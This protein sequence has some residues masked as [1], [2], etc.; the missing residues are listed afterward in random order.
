MSNR[1][2]RGYRDGRIEE[3][4]TK[5][6]PRFRIVWREPK[7]F[8][9]PDLGK[10]RM[11]KGGF[12]TRRDAQSQLRK[13]LSRVEDGQP[14]PGGGAITVRTFLTEF[15]AAHRVYSSTAET[16]AKIARL[17][18]YPH[19]G[20]RKLTTI[21]PE[22]LAGLYRLLEER[23]GQKGQPLSPS[24]VA[25][26]H[27]VLSV[28]FGSPTAMRLVGHNPALARLSQPPRAT[29]V[30]AARTPV[31]VW[32]IPQLHD[33]LSWNETSGDPNWA[34]WQLVAE[35]G[36]RR[37]EVAALTWGDLDMRGSVLRVQRTVALV[38]GPDGRLLTKEKPTKGYKSRVVA[39]Y[40][41]TVDALKRH[42]EAV[43]KTY[44]FA[45]IKADK[46]MPVDVADYAAI[47]QRVGSMW[48]AHCKRFLTT[49]GQEST[50]AVTL[51]GLRHT[52]ATHLFLAGVH[53]K[54]VQERLGH[55]NAS[56][57]Q[58]I[59]THMLPTTQADAITKLTALRKDV[60]ASDDSG[61]GDPDPVAAVDK[62]RKLLAAAD[63]GEGDALAQLTALRQILLTDAPSAA[64]SE[65]VD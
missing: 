50:P 28:A 15:L 36:I 8:E 55:A 19:I 46:P 35:T 47:P 45:A 31:I 12:R 54:I 38:H 23:G 56:I 53:P 13:E 2:R 26:V 62:L 16:Y 27:E 21:R 6:G 48:A 7:D 20:D 9:H 43:A 63:R 5:Q 29:E 32:D 41:E 14:A 3:Y 10:R 65:R 1:P 40:P 44:G 59:Y 34:I 33:F 30:K 52:H 49:E 17:Y 58:N 60:L 37:G 25:K 39:L 22:T 24:T 57:T 61:T 64:E 4:A 42:R 18:I 11:S 51:H